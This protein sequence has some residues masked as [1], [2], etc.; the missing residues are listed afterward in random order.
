MSAGEHDDMVWIEPGQD[1]EQINAEIESG[2]AEVAPAAT[3]RVT[4][5]PPIVGAALLGLDE[6]GA[7]ADAQARA[8]S[9][10]GG[11]FRRL[12]SVG[13]GSRASATRS[14]RSG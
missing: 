14:G 11:A 7:G 6:L 10:L 2:L 9:E 3:G 8:R 4:S 12:E 5:S 13:Q 1:Q